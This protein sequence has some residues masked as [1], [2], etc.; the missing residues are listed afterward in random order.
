MRNT[1]W[2]LVLSI[3]VGLTTPAFC[4]DS[5]A[6]AALSA[7]VVTFSAW[8]HR[9]DGPDQLPAG[10]TTFRL[11][12]KGKE[13]HQL[14]LL[15][16]EQGR[17]PADLAAA[18]KTGGRTVPTWAKHMGG[19]NGVDAGKASEATVY[20]E[21]GSYVIICAIPGK[22]HQ[23]H[24]VLGMQKA[25]QVTDTRP[26]PAEFDG[27]FHMAMF[28]YEFVVVQPLRKGR[29]TFYVINRGGLTHQVTLVRLNPDISAEDV[30]TALERDNPSLPG[31]FIGGMS[32]LEPGRDGTFVAN[33]T[34]GRYAI[35]CLFSNPHA[36]ES[37][38]AKG[39]VMN[40]TIE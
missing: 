36:R 21:P 37:H 6:N 14:Q 13:P 40:F 1:H 25:L 18:L 24:A 12:N 15:K 9:F 10:K 8:E 16:L 26:A 29:H 35:M 17:S 31:A 20:L 27:N 33:L 4:A 22:D 39:M 30:L 19:P 5:P 2:F 3:C 23:S 28:E 32:G 11:Q 7:E 38:A 34:P